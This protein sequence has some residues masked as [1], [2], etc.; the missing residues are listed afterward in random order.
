M[1]RIRVDD[2]PKATTLYVEGRLAGDFV[3]ELRRVWT[4]VRTEM[5]Q[6]ETVV[7]LCSVRVVDSAGR[8]L[9]GQMHGWGTR[10]AGNGL[11]IG[12]L[13]EEI[14]NAGSLR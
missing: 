11:C 7:D 2:Q 12:P 1:M 14:V 4:C 3:D 5:P 13:I 10:L 9:L 6:K 8:K